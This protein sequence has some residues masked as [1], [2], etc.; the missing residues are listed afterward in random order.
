MISIIIPVYNAGPYL[1]RCLCSVKTQTYSNWECVL[2][3]DG[4]KDDSG[5]ICDKWQSEDSRFRVVHQKNQGASV[6]RQVGIATAKGEYL[7]FVDA[8]DV[9]EPDYLE[10]LHSSLCDLDAEI[11]A[12]DF[13]KHRESESVIVD[14]N[15]L[16]RILET[17]ELHQRF[18]KY[19][20][21]GYPG[22]IYK[23][24]VFDGI[25]FP[26]A[27]INEDYVVMVQL[28]HKCQ[29]MA[30][31][32]ISLYHYMMHEGSLS[33]QK[34]S[35][36]AMEEWENKHWVYS[37]YKGLSAS[38]WMAFAEAQAAESCCKLVKA[39][40]HGADKDDYRNVKTEMQSFLRSHLLSL[41][42]SSHLLL[43]LKI[44]CIKRAFE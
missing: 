5:S 13:I 33:N 38:K 29:R 21:W 36:R 44:I 18:F 17:E 26:K 34:I 11:A 22:K 1:D 19:E 40:D 15:P 41:L 9:V 7:S 14:R 32:P 39:I 10:K 3:D 31:V 8:D 20:F 35:P 43:G 16:P 28:F 2:V 42:F 23:R 27:T 25:Y 24:D 37:F 4:S 6:A 12:C 30:Y